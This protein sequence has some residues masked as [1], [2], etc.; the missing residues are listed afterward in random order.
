MAYQK[1]LKSTPAKATFFS[2]VQTLLKAKFKVNCKDNKTQSTTMGFLKTVDLNQNARAD[3]A[4]G[5]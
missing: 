5:K 1:S 2:T 4:Q 3:S